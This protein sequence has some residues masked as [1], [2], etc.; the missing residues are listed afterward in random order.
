MARKKRQGLL[1]LLAAMPWP[2]GVVL[3]LA[4]FFVIRFGFPWHVGRPGNDSAIALAKGLAEGPAPI[5]AWFAL[6]VCWFGAGLSYLKQRQRAQLFDD[7]ARNL[8]LTSLGWRQFER[9]VAEWFHREGYRVVEAGGGGPDGGIDLKVRKGERVEIV[10][11][12]QWRQRQVAVATVR[13]MWGLLHHHQADAVW[14]FCIGTFTPDAAA[15][16]A[17]KPL[18]LVTGTELGGL[19]KQTGTSPTPPCPLPA[20][21]ACAERGD[22]GVSDQRRK[23][24]RAEQQAHQKLLSGLRVLPEPPRNATH[25]LLVTH[26]GVTGRRI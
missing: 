5:F 24:E 19:I 2:A 18:R 10:Q 6:L 3:A 26:R 9:L 7:Q 13:E 17:G 11:C 16:A 4:A 22:S 15:F 8:K 14:I 12:K 20:A 23:A 1:E 25:A 21:R